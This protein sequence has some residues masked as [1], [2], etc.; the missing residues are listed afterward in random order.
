MEYDQ[1]N[2]RRIAL[3]NCY[4]NLE[5]VYDESKQYTEVVQY[6]WQCIEI[7]KGYCDEDDVRYIYAISV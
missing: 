6:Y 3:A 7:F 1:N 4:M 5:A 2:V